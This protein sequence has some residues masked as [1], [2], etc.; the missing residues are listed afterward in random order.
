MDF[1]GSPHP[2]R[3][4][5]RYGKFELD[6]IGLSFYREMIFLLENTYLSG[7]EFR[8]SL[9]RAIGVEEYQAE[10]NIWGFGITEPRFNGELEKWK[11][12]YEKSN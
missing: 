8:I 3:I 1:N 4:M 11:W 12:N 6:Y 10:E 7:R 9:L 2:L 5:N